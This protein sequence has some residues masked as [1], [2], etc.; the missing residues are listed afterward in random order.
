MRGTLRI[1]LAHHD[2]SY[3]VHL[4]E[5]LEAGGIPSGQ[6]TAVSRLAEI[7]PTLAR[8]AHDALLLDLGMPGGVAVSWM[9]T[10]APGL[11][12]PIVALTVDDSEQA[13]V[14][15]LAAGAEDF[16]ACSRIGHGQL[17][18]AIRHALERRHSEDAIRLREEQLRQSQK[19]EAVGRLAG[20]I[21]HDFSNLLMVIMASSERM[22]D[23]VAVGHPLR[24][25]AETIRA[26]CERAAGLTRQL[27]AF[28]RKQVLEPQRVDLRA[29][30]QAIGRLL[31]PLIGEHIFMV[32]EAEA[33]LWSVDADPLQLEQVIMNLALN[34]RD[35]MP[36]GGALRVALKNAVVADGVVGH[37]MEPLSPGSYAVLEVS[38][39]GEGMDAETLAHACEPFFT[40]KDASK[41]T[42]LGLATVYGIVRQSRGHLVIRSAPGSGTTIQVFLPKAEGP[43]PERPVRHDVPDRDLR[44]RET[45]LL[46]EDEGAVRELVQA[47]LESSGYAVIATGG[48]EDALACAARHEGPISALISDIVMPGGTGQE[49]AKRLLVAR[50]SLK[51]LFMSGY[52]EQ[53]AVP[54]AP[55][56]GVAFLPKPF[57]RKLLLQKLRELLEA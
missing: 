13:A 21:A 32:T 51:V 31:A 37:D 30:V 11:P 6:I 3:V 18:R 48:M 23:S 2:P 24:G 40:T 34:A 28:S 15:A 42:G 25:E 5:C 55:G 10:N 27:L 54:L 41:G 46:T 35:A 8:N 57:T 49:L 17:I 33:E 9:R 56:S 12:V 29:V 36:D 1:L 4:R 26:N 45:V 16:V 47:V 44:G 19:M 22:L 14:E 52:P 20:G 39:S 7:K 53:D 43:W 38:D 50:P